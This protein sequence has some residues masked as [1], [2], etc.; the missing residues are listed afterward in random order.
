MEIY[1]KKYLGYNNKEKKKMQD[2]DDP[3]LLQL[4]SNLKNYW[5]I[6]L[7]THSMLDKLNVLEEIYT[8]I[9]IE[10]CLLN[11][12]KDNALKDFIIKYSI[13]QLEDIFL[14][15]QH[16]KMTFDFY[17]ASKTDFIDVDFLHALDI[18]IQSLIS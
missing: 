1:Q 7:S 4:I 11:K 10:F 16:F 15:L 13:Y 18:T 12:K 9:N 17:I 8:Y 5:E 14:V 6:F 2:I 3:E